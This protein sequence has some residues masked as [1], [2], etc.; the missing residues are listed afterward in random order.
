MRIGQFFRGWRL[1]VLAVVLTGLALGAGSGR[2]GDDD[3]DE[4]GEWG[5]VFTLTNRSAGNELAV[6]ERD[7]RGRLANPVFLPTGGKG[8]GTGLGNQGALALGDDSQYLYAVNPGSNTITVFQ[9]GRRGARA[10]QVVNSGGTRP[11]SLTVREDLLYVLNAGGGTAGGADSIAGFEI[12]DHGQLS[13]LRNSVALLSAANTGPAQIGFNSD[14]DVLIVTEKGTNTIDLFAVNKNGLPAGRKSVASNGKTP[15]GFAFTRDDL[16][17]VSEAFGGAANASAVSSYD[18]DADAGLLKVISPSVPTTKTAACW[19]AI[20]SNGEYAY[21]TNT[22]SGTV[23]G[24][25]IGGSGKLAIL[26]ANGVTA[27]TG[28]APTDVVNLGN[29]GLFVLNSGDGTVASYAIGQSGALT[30]SQTVGGLPTRA[31]GLVV[32]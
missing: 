31:T 20:A 24:Y 27:T 21:T 17:V 18:L 12:G 22:G 30:A 13:P 7:G 6:F 16:L 23:T 25:K 32:R 8:T 2:A 15:F 29:R 19:I 4:L 5:A 26:N 10:V 11:I 3:R 9:L 28:A 14:G 1:G